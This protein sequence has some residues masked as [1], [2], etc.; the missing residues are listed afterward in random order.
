MSEP[1]VAFD[2]DADG[3]LDIVSWPKDPTRLAFLAFDRNND[4]TINDASE[5][6]G[7]HTV[8]G[9]TD[10]FSALAR[11][12]ELEGPV[13]IGEVNGSSALFGKLLLWQDFNRDGVS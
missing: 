13:Q 12:L 3:V 8:P 7:D 11:L 1:D 9:A 6:F 10:G 2:I 4:G 5:L